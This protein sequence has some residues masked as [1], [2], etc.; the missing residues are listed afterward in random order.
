M[1]ELKEFFGESYHEELRQN[2]PDGELTMIDGLPIVARV[3]TG[4]DFDN[5][6]GD[7]YPAKVEIV[8]NQDQSVKTAFVYEDFTYI[9]KIISFPE[10]ISEQESE[11]SP[12]QIECAVGNEVYLKFYQGKT[13]D[14]LVCC[15]FEEHE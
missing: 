5:W 8:R 1:D 11:L 12:L 10:F 9:F 13:G 4:G 3:N 7:L 6:S 14:F 15:K 2:L